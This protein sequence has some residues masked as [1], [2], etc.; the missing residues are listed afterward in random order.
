MEK[1]HAVGRRKTAS[2]R[3]WL[4]PNGSGKIIINDRNLDD[5]F[6]TLSLREKVLM[7]LKLLKKE[8]DFDIYVYVRGGGTTGQAE[9]IR[10][11]IAR[12]LVLFDESNRQLMRRYGLLTRDPRMVERKK[13]G[14]K[15]A[16]KS[17]QWTKR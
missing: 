15:K 16:R 17:P 9:A 6:P 14:K 8:K 3:V 7:P 11:G 5:Y 13:Y 12:A 4:V 10:H 2:A 1:I